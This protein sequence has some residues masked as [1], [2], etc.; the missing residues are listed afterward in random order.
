MNGPSSTLVDRLEATLGEPIKIG[1][2]T[3]HSG[4]YIMGDIDGIMLIPKTLV[5][6]CVD[7]V[8]TLINTESLVRKAILSGVD[9][10]EAYLRY[11]RF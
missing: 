4:G 3:I 7:R 10:K 9:P 8:E 5:N 6:D 2:L 11:G 1:A